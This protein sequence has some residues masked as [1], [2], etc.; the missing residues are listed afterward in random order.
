MEWRIKAERRFVGKR[1][2]VREGDRT[3]GEASLVESD[4]AAMASIRSV[5]AEDAK[6]LSGVLIDGH[7]AATVVTKLRGDILS[8]TGDI[9]RR[10]A[11]SMAMVAACRCFGKAVDYDTVFAL[12]GNGFAPDIRPGEP[13]RSFWPYQG[14][15]R[16]LD[17]VCSALGLSYRAFNVAQAPSGGCPSSF[18]KAA[19]QMDEWRATYRSPVIDEVERI[20]ANGEALLSMGEWFYTPQVCWTEWGFVTSTDMHGSRR[21]PD[22]GLYGYASN[23]RGDNEVDFVRDGYVLGLRSAPTRATDTDR[24]ILKRASDR[25]MGK[26]SAGDREIVFGVKA[27]DAWVKSMVEVKGFCPGCYSRDPA[28]TWHCAADVAVPTVEGS[29]FSATWLRALADKKDGR[30]AAHLRAAANH[31]DRIVAL[32]EPALR[33]EGPESYRAITGDLQKQRAHAEK[34]LRPVRA[35]LSAAGRE[36][37]TALE[38]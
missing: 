7:L 33:H 35:E 2:V 20:W 22:G 5:P 31:Y 11:F 14:R 21:R 6:C 19:D 1:V 26:L 15:E 23:G 17:L 38:L 8:F 24:Q 28:N 4:G 37:Q 36:M 10:D 13:E 27:L 9:Y 34:V 18:P 3:V 25:I 30:S 16:N 12:S 32:F 29:R